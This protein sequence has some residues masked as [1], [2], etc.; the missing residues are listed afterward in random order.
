MAIDS[1]TVLPE[2]N[3]LSEKKNSLSREKSIRLAKGFSR[4]LWGM[5]LS[6]IL[7]TGLVKIDLLSHL[8]LPI[9]V[10]GMLLVYWGI[11]LLCMSSSITPKWSFHTRITLSIVFLQIYFI[12]FLYWWKQMPFVTYYILNMAAFLFS[13]TFVLFWV[14]LLAGEVARALDDKT[15][16]IESRISG[17]SVLFLMVLPI[18][19][20]FFYCIYAS[21]RHSTS[22]YSEIIQTYY[23]LPRWIYALFFLPLTLTLMIIWKTKKRCLA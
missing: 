18:S 2:V 19:L 16:F 13:V 1:T 12:P 17:W 11:A 6:L 3:A 15:F 10:V 4:L 21:V 20:F 9:F 14:N 5:I 8:R 23:Y 22:L 7:F